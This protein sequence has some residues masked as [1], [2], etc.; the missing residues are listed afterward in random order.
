M[1]PAEHGKARNRK[2]RFPRGR[3]QGCSGNG[4]RRGKE[5]VDAVV[6][7]P[8]RTGCEREVRRSRHRRFAPRGSSMSPA[9]RRRLPATPVCSWTAA[10][11]LSPSGP[12]TCSRRPSISRPWHCLKTGSGSGVKRR[13]KG[14]FPLPRRQRRP[15]TPRGAGRREPAWLDTSGSPEKGG[16]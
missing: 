9:T 15:D 4:A 2:C 1:R 3:R 7:D 8:P 16:F 13:H 10:T 6:L 5:A 14:D 11:P 12:L